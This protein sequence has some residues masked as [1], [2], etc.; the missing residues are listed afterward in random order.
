[1]RRV[2][3]P[4]DD[5]ADSLRSINVRS[6][7]FCRSQFTAPWGFRVD[8]TAM[9]KFHL[10]LAGEAYLALDGESGPR[11]LVAGDVVVLPHGTGHAVTDA[12]GSPAPSLEGILVDQVVGEAGTMS[13]GGGGRATTVV[14]GGFGT[15]AL[16]ADLIEQ[17]PRILVLGSARDGV[18]RWLEPLA[19]LLAAERPPSPGDGAVLAKVADVFLTE[20]LRQYLASHRLLRLQ[21]T[22]SDDDKPIAMALRLMRDNPGWPWTIADLARAVSLSRTAFTLR[23]RHAVGEPPMT[24]LTRLRLSGGAGYLTSTSRTIGDIAREVGYDSE[25]SFSK[26]F[27]RIYGRSP[28]AFRTAW[29]A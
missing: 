16:P 8:D 5:L 21:I 2:S 27:K 10:V 29:A 15:D 18:T 6:V 7:V 22:A 3:P 26:A 14:C 19:A 24:H 17:L 1:M 11:H 13:Y 9:A 23:F 20:S 12:P 28:G 4:G 25:A